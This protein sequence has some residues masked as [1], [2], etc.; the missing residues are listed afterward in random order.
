MRAARGYAR[1]MG[2]KRAIDVAVVVAVFF[3]TVGM[4]GGEGARTHDAEHTRDLR[5]IALA[6]ASALP[7]FLRR[8]SPLGA[9]ALAATASVLISALGYRSGPPL[10]ATVALLFVGMYPTVTPEGR[11]LTVATVVAFYLLHVAA[12]WF[13]G[14]DS[15]LVPLLLG[16]LVWG[17]AWVVGDRVRQRRERVLE[18][19][20]RADRERQIA[21]AE[22]RTRIARDL[23]D[24]AGHALNVILVQSGAARLLAEKDPAQARAALETIEAVARD[25]VDEIDRMVRVL[26]DDGWGGD[27]EP[28]LGLGALERLVRS[29]ADAG[30]AVDA[31]TRGRPRPL[32]RAVD[33]AAYRIVQEALTNAARHGVSG[34]QLEV[35]Y[36]ERAL[37]LTVT[38]ATRASDHV[39]GHG[40]VGMRERAAMLGGRIDVE[41][42]GGT[43]R[44]RAE[45]PYERRA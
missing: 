31:T 20:V 40:I 7:L 25:T 43:F 3:F 26:R 37:R 44:V 27:V 35:S 9:F 33:Q 36:S 19:R 21:V 12:V 17:G 18:E 15:P 24:S 45:L 10:G 30:L 1:A 42:G 39:E 16:A 13:G 2:R 23:H 8:R 41:S 28:P 6:A 32:P 38:N 34:A 11:R 22:E 4:I 14:E 5:G 29:H